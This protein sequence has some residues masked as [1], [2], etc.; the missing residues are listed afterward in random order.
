V[1]NI[2]LPK[3]HNVNFSYWEWKTF[4][5]TFDFIVL[6]S[7]IVGLSAA[8]HLKKINKKATVLVLERGLMPSGAS[9]KNAGFAC[10]GSA[11]EILADLARMNHETV[12][13]TVKMRWDGLKLLR[14]T[15]G[16]KNICYKSYGGYELFTDKQS[17]EKVLV[18]VA[19]VNENM[20]H[21]IG[22]KNCYVAKNKKD[23]AFKNLKGIIKNKF[24]GQIDTALMMKTLLQLCIKNNVDILNSVIIEN[25]S[26]QTNKVEL[27][28]QSGIFSADKVIVATNGFANELLKLKDVKPARAQVL[29]TKPIEGL[30]IKGAFHFDEGYYY[31]RNIDN[32]I[33]FGGGRNLDFEGENT[34]ELGLNN[35]IQERLK[36]LLKDFILPNEKFDIEQQWSGI[37]G[38]GN[39]KKPIITPVGKN[40]VA[41][42]RMGGMGIAIGSLVGKNA[43]E[44]ASGKE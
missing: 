14:T 37:M 30:K 27:V 16:D 32:R 18:N 38:V 15:L 12:W 35:G 36:L 8:L 21:V 2:F 31:F 4:F 6:G 25:I 29:I 5:R 23:F 17:F 41:A 3:T 39:E 26:Q 22:E 24:E 44:M 7:G 11:G 33:L 28:S 42:V 19:S 1:P 13:E 10:F 34:H 9:T 43:A 40:I 20:R